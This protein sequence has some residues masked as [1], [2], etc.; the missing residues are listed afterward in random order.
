MSDMFVG[1]QAPLY[2]NVHIKVFNRNTGKISAERHAKNRITKLMLW[3]IAQFLMGAFNDSTPDKIYEVIPRYVAL[4]SNKAGADAETA[5]VTTNVTV[6]DARLLNEYKSI[7]NEQTSRCARISIE[8]RQHVTMNAKFT[9]PFIKLTFSAY[10]SSSDYNNLEIGEAGLFSKEQGNSC[11]ARVV[12]SPFTKRDDEVI[13]IKWE[14]TLLSYGATKYAE[15]VNIEGPSRVV[16]PLIYTP[17]K[18]KFTSIG[19]FYDADT[20]YL[21]DSDQVPMIEVRSDGTFYS[22]ISEEDILKSS[23]AEY[24]DAAGIDCKSIYNQIMNCYIKDYKLR[25]KDNNELTYIYIAPKQKIPATKTLLTDKDGHFLRDAESYQLT[26]TDPPTGIMKA[27]PLMM[28]QAFKEEK[29]YITTDTGYRLIP[30]EN[31]GDYTVR[32]PEGNTTL[33]KVVDDEIFQQDQDNLAHYTSMQLHLYNHVIVKSTGEST[34]YVYNDAGVISSRV[35]DSRSDTALNAYLIEAD[36]D[37]ISTSK[38]RVYEDNGFD[39]LVDTGYWIDWGNDKEIYNESVDTLYHVTN[40]NYIAI[41]EYSQLKA[42]IL[43]SDATDRTISWGIVN[44]AIAK[45]SASG[46]VQGWNVGETTA[47]A[48]TS[49]GVKARV[50]IEVIKDL[51]HIA[52]KSITLDPS[53]INFTVDDAITGTVVVTA[54]VNPVYATY[55]TVVWSMDAAG[56]LLCDYVPL[57][58]NKCKVMLRGEDVGR[59]YLI[60]QTGDGVT[61]KCLI[62]VTTTKNV[63]DCPDPYHDV[64]QA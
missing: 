8:G 13:D 6:N 20:Q 26:S 42:N 39:K 54:K 14:I 48:S 34:D 47:V 46:S 53:I 38:Y 17:Y 50:T 10:V 29:T 43:P 28:A 44:T 45:I 30:A 3:G 4:G 62:N 2:Q 58:D 27:Y 41:G 12:F 49:N 11:L 1:S 55:S 52:T 24:C 31:P 37:G 56:Q 63:D 15:E 51:A 59:G 64:I 21:Y 36:A 16:V 32:T 33:Y 23:W 18:I 9:D 7:A 61:A 25:I 57:G 19:L 60:A 35:V 40:D 22:D 5:N